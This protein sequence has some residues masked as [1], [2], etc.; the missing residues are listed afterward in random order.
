[1]TDPKTTIDSDASDPTSRIVS[2][3]LSLLSN[4]FDNVDALV[5]TVAKDAMTV[6]RESEGLR[7]ALRAGV[8]SVGQ[9]LRS[10]WTKPAPA[11]E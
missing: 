11:A 4:V 9:E 2:A 8:V 3:S 6:V 7:E 1:M 5:T 10:L